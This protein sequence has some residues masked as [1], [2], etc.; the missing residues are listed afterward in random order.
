MISVVSMKEAKV[1]QRGN[2]YHKTVK[3]K[4]KPADK[5]SSQQNKPHNNIKHTHITTKPHSA[6]RTQVETRVN[7]S[8]RIRD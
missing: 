5:K 4:T 3:T 2:Q 7:I 6:T 8:S 1:Y